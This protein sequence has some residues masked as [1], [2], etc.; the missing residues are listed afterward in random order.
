MTTI[1]PLRDI[2]LKPVP[3]EALNRFCIPASAGCKIDLNS[4]LRNSERKNSVPLR[5]L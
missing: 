5:A 2:S 3:I 4:P 1:S